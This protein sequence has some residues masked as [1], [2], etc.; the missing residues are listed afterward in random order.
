MKAS[1][2][3]QSAVAAAAKKQPKKPGL[4][5]RVAGAVNRGIE[6]H[7]AANK[8]L[9]KAASETGKTIRNIAT[10]VGGVAREAGK[11]ASGAARLAGHVARKGLSDEYIMA[12]LIDEGYA[13]TENAAKAIFEN[14]SEDW[15]ESIVEEI[16][17]LDEITASMGRRA[18]QYRQ[19]Q[20][21]EAFMRRQKEH[22]ER[23]ENDPD[24]RQ[25]QENLR[26]IHSR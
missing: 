5:D 16:E 8:S 25:K 15:R 4:L 11:G 18:K 17:Q 6:R 21:Q 24:Y 20:E 13:K 12:Y 2:Q 26:K 10:R 9:N 19:N 22:Q 23:M 7:N 3:R 1:L 14:M